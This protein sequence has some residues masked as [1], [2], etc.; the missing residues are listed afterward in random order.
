MFVTGL[1]AYRTG[2]GS[3]FVYDDIP[4]IVQNPTIRSLWPLTTPLSPPRTGGIT[5]SGR[6]FLNLTLALNQALG[7]D[8]ASFRVTNVLIHIAA[9]L[10]LFGVVRRTLLLPRLRPRLGAAALPLASIIALVWTLHPLQTEAVSYVVQRAESLMGCLYFLTL[11]AFIRGAEATG[12]GRAWFVASVAACWLGM[13]T[14]EVMVSAPVIVW[15]YDRTFLSGGFRS[16]IV[17]RPAVYAG[18]AAGWILLFALVFSLGG[19]RGGSIGPG[20]GVGWWAYWATQFDALVHYVRL[21]FWPQPLV[22]DY[23]TAW[24][25]SVARVLPNALLVIGAVGLAVVALRRWPAFGFPLAFCFAIL[26]PTSLMPGPTQLLAEHRMYL[27]SAG[28]LAVALATGHRL[29]GRAARAAAALLFVAFAVLTAARNRVYRDEVGL[30]RDTLAKSPGNVRAEK[31]LANALVAAGRVSESVP[32]YETALALAPDDAAAHTNFANALLKLGRADEALRH[33]R[34][35]AALQPARPEMHNNLGTALAERRD[36]AGAIA[37]FD[38]AVRQ[39]PAYAEA[40]FNRGT[41]LQL[42]GHAAE[43]VAAFE[44]VLALQPDYPDAEYNLAV[45][46]SNLGR[47][48]EAIA[49]YQRA[50]QQKDDPAAHNNLGALLAEAGRFPEAIA[51]FE[52]VVRLTPDDADAQRNLVR[53]RSELRRATGPGSK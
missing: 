4:S 24:T 17:K 32:A 21:V 40:H 6:P 7:G 16:A 35:A 3:P 52:A 49:H 37:E 46:L 20:V 50:L 38:T 19:N 15:L 36:F 2:I 47:P 26:A 13:A 28:V 51:E 53:A 8:V 43:A 9:G 39:R 22:F 11:Y 10:A 18:L 12:A 23:A 30:W 27:A 29:L 25:S 1:L 45:G 31:G 41:A 14:K 48:T 44:R 34:T 42:S 33:F 5:V